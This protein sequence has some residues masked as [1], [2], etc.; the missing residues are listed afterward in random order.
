[1]K[2]VTQRQ[3]DKRR[4]PKDGA[5]RATRKSLD[6]TETYSKTQAFTFHLSVPKSMAS[7]LSHPVSPP[8]TQNRP[9]HSLFALQLR[10]AVE[11]G[12]SAS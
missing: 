3:R 7:L 12:G 2:S 6:Q 5:I 11:D 8:V 10:D 1:M 4:E 9:G